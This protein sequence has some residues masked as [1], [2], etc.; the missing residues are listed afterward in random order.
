L[1]L[2]SDLG[3]GGDR[4]LVVG[5][6]R[7]AR[8][9]RRLAADHPDRL[10]GAALLDIMPME[11]A[12]NQGQDGYARRYYH[13][14]FM[15]QRGLAEEVM[16][17]MPRA[18]ALNQFERAHVPL[19]PADIE[20]YVA[21][22]SRPHSIQASLGDYRT[23]FEVDRPC[24]EAE[25]AQGKRIQVPLLVLWGGEGNLRDA[26]VLE[27]WRRRAVDVRGGP[28]AGSAHYIPEEQPQGVVEAVLT[29]AAALGVV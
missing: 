4:L 12:F 18:F 29:F 16:G 13:W 7:G 21:A 26:P 24:W 19:D 17:A 27:E 20:H 25:L 9:A 6:D 3:F 28:I 8:V 14:Y 11:W 22:F 1:R 2:G 10:V 15:L 23:A 5:H